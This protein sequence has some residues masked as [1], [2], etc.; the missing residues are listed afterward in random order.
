MKR[1]EGTINALSRW[2]SWVG[3]GFL[4]A[5]M[6][7]TVGNIIARHVYEPWGGTAIVVGWLAAPLAAFA[8]AYTQQRKGH[9]RIDI[10]VSRFR[11]R[12]QS[13]IDSIMFLIGAA[14]FGV[15]T[16]Q[17]VK[18]ANRYRELGQIDASTG[19]RFYPFIYAVGV[20]CAFLCLVLLI[21]FLK[22]L[23]QA[24]KK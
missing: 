12:V 1:L 14:L 11:P 19:I 21:D 5:L 10:L 16:W 24:V 3:G 9:S 23:V 4:L 2:L 17:V 18:L 8:L 22:S 15:G 20:G 6:L 7:L 13:I